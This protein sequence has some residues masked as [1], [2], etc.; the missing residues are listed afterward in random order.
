MGMVV[1]AGIAAA[2]QPLKRY[3]D[4]SILGTEGVLRKRRDELARLIGPLLDE[5]QG[6]N[7]RVA[8][9]HLGLFRATLASEQSRSEGRSAALDQ[10]AARWTHHSEA[11]GVLIRELDK[12]TAAALLRVEGRERLARSLKRATRVPGVC[13]LAEFENIAFSESRLFPPDIGEKLA[14]GRVPSIGGEAAG[15]LSYTLDLIDAPARLSRADSASATVCVDDDLP[16]G[17]AETWSDA[18]T[19]H[20][21]KHIRIEST[22]RTSGS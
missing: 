15:A 16:A 20:I 1:G 22:R 2:L 12:E 7:E 11:L 14:A 13:I 6:E 21:G 19:S 8:D 4:K 18:L 9:E 3:I 10:L 17:I 5:L